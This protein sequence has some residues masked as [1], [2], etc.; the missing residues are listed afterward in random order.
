ME[1]RPQDIT[2]IEREKRVQEVEQLIMQGASV[3]DIIQYCAKTFKVNQRVVYDYIA[4]ARESIK[5][6]FKTLFNPE[7]FKAN[8]FKRLEDLYKNS[9]DIEDFKECRNILRDLRDMLGIDEATKTNLNVSSNEI[10]PLSF[11]KS[12]NDKD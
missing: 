12:N 10:T 3:N 1:K 8:I 4:E 9:Y 7:Y 11:F 6:N 2:K 5:E